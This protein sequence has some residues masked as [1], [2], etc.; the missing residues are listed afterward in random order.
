M[1]AVNSKCLAVV[2]VVFLTSWLAF[3]T[4]AGEPELPGLDAVATAP[5]TGFRPF[6]RSWLALAKMELGRQNAPLS[7]IRLAV[8]LS[9]GSYST[10]AW[11]EA[12]VRN[13][14]RGFQEH[15]LLTGS[16]WHE[17]RCSPQGCIIAFQVA[18]RNSLNRSA[19]LTA[20]LLEYLHP[21]SK[22]GEFAQSLDD[23]D[24]KEHFVVYFFVVEE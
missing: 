16:I 5:Y 4:H 1:L 2:I 19:E 11:S 22:L 20:D 18:G 13:V 7:A 23:P 15:P 21:T 8:D 12:A 24:S 14:G 3:R 9:S 17:V 6:T 10:N